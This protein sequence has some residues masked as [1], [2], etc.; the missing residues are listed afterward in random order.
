MSRGLS[1]IEVVAVVGIASVVGISIVAIY[2]KLR[3]SRD[4][5]HTQTMI[6][7]TISTARVQAV[8]GLHDTGWGVYTDTDAVT[9]F[10]GASY[11]SR[12][13]DT[14][15]DLPVTIAVSGDREYVF[16]TIYGT[17]TAGSM[18]LTHEGV[19]KEITVNAQ[20]TITTN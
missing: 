5:T 15:Y 18:T 20:G 2:P 9:L 11:A 10:E 13:A 3:T 17:T 7:D 4:F 8:S 16:E 6:I 12:T 1:L 19:V 14:V